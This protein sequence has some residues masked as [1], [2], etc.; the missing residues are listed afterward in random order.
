MLEPT[1]TMKKKRKKET[2]Q[3]HLMCTHHL[4]FERN[5]D[6]RFSL[7]CDDEKKKKR[8]KIRNVYMWKKII[9]MREQDVDVDK[10]KNVFKKSYFTQKPKRKRI[11]THPKA[12]FLS[13]TRARREIYLL[14]LP[15]HLD[16]AFMCCIDWH[17][18]R[19]KKR[20]LS[21]SHVHRGE[22]ETHKWAC[23]AVKSTKVL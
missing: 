6:S 14:K 20:S 15:F 2:L 5:F 17:T 22:F 13:S 7:S 1:G 12:F 8:K 19:P 9:W 16:A 10:Q 3:V 23:I 18:R 11:L 21:A 4:F